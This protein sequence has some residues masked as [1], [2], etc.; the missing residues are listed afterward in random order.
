MA[1]P[2]NGMN[3]SATKKRLRKIR[4]SRGEKGPREKSEGTRRNSKGAEKGR[5]ADPEERI[6]L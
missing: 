3:S 1:P 4:P 5:D 6:I 2:K